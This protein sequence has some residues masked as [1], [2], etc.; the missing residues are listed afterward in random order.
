MINMHGSSKFSGWKGGGGFEE[1]LFR[2]GGGGGGGVE[3]YMYITSFYH[4][5]LRNLNFPGKGVRL[6]PDPEPDPT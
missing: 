2:G 1:Y 3:T 5:N 6:S 4:V